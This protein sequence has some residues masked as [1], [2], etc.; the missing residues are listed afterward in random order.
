MDPDDLFRIRPRIFRVPEPDYSIRILPMLFKQILKLFK[1]PYT[2]SKRR[3]YQL[4]AIFYILILLFFLSG[5]IRIQEKNL[6]L[7]GSGFTTPKF[8]QMH[9]DITKK[10][11]PLDH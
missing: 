3:I 1:T 2:Q 7:T 5:R 8:K 6:N 4:Y 11:Y 10:E 9:I